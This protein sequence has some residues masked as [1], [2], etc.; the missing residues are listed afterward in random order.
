VNGTGTNLK[1]T[2]KKRDN[3][4]NHKNAL[5]KNRFN[6]L[7]KDPESFFTDGFGFLD[8]IFVAILLKLNFL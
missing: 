7:M 5:N 8:V 6:L 3:P 2:T 4:R 1:S